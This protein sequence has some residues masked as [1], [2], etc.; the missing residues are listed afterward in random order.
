MT[1]TRVLCL[2]HA[3]IVPVSLYQAWFYEHIDNP[4]PE[5][6]DI[7]ELCVRTGMTMVSR[8]CMCVCMCVCVC[9]CVC[10]KGTV[11]TLFQELSAINTIPRFANVSHLVIH[12]ITLIFSGSSHSLVQ[13]STPEI[14]TQSAVRGWAA[15][16]ERNLISWRPQL[17]SVCSRSALGFCNQL[18]AK[19][20]MQPGMVLF[21]VFLFLTESER[22]DVSFKVTSPAF[23]GYRLFIR[24]HEYSTLCLSGICMLS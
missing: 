13:C 22:T 18:P 15:E 3:L 16:C 14:G 10:V 1:I 24:A 23:W 19:Y 8:L 20:A 5:I 2:S 7:T 6:V 12:D 11:W 21:S 4:Y 9:V 17:Q